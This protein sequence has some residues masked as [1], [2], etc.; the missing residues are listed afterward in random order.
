MS[1]RTSPAI[2]AAIFE[3]IHLYVP[4]GDREYLARKYWR[5]SQSYDFHPSDMSIENTL[6]DLDLARR[7]AH[8]N[9]GYVM[10]YADDKG[11]WPSERPDG[12]DGA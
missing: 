7:V 1:D 10:K 4:P 3:D 2:F 9:D 12:G 5:M 11:A 8:P 6:L